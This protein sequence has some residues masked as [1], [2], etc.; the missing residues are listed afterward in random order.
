MTELKQKKLFTGRLSMPLLAVFCTLLWGSAFPFVKLGYAAFGI[1]GDASVYTKLLFAGP[2]FGLAGVVVLA[3]GSIAARRPLG[4]RKSELGPILL[5][6]LVQTVLQYIFFYVGLSNTTGTLGSILTSTSAFF[7]VLGA[8]LFFRSDKLTGA[9]VAGCVVGF[10]GVLLAAGGGDLA[11]RLTGEGFMVLSA[12]ANAGSSLLARRYAQ[13]IS[14]IALTGW[15]LALGGGALTAAGLVGGGRFPQV[16]GG[17]IAVLAYL[18]LLS[19]V[20]FSLWT[21]LL[22]YNAAGRVCV[23]NFLIPIFGTLLSILVLGEE[24]LQLKYLGALALVC[25][26]IWLVNRKK[27]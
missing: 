14:P 13:G 9:G 12:A 26:G 5:V 10:L 24:A 16:T 6:A 7:A 19:A 20:A 18:V 17:G 15:G 27:A 23:F 2:R 3:V 8:P 4:F 22:K 25:A 11:F 1:G 21:T